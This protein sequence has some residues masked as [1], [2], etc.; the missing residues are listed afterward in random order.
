MGARH[1]VVVSVG[2][3]SRQCYAVYYYYE[4]RTG[5]RVRS[6][7]IESSGWKWNGTARASPTGR[8]PAA[9]A[10]D[11]HRRARRRCLVVASSSSVPFLTVPQVETCKVRLPCST[12][13]MGKGFV[14]RSPRASLHSLT[15][16]AK[17]CLVHLV[18]IAFACHI[19]RRRVARGRCCFEAW[20]SLPLVLLA[21]NTS[22]SCL[23]MRPVPGVAVCQQRVSIYNHGCHCHQTR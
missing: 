12:H 21:H 5:R 1:I 7:P 16:K 4:H 14:V 22:P 2:Y 9:Q 15:A 17:S 6:H 23:C 13:G 3:S 8:A 20:S 11:V 10:R 18:H 19:Y